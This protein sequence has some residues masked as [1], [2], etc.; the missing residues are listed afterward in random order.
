MQRVVRPRPQRLSPPLLHALRGS[1]SSSVFRRQALFQ[2]PRKGPCCTRC[3]FSKLSRSA[4]AGD[5]RASGRRRPEPFLTPP[6]IPSAPELQPT[7]PPLQAAPL[8]TAQPRTSCYPAARPQLRRWLSFRAH[9]D[10]LGSPHLVL[11]AQ[12]GVPELRRRLRGSVGQRALKQRPRV[13]QVALACQC[14]VRG[15]KQARTF[16]SWAEL[17]G[18]R[19]RTE[20]RDERAEEK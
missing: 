18:G 5:W 8:C 15:R 9:L 11:K 14:S 2:R 13:G 19:R 7:P 12:K 20:G 10:G 17:G 4:A 6:N 16:L 1:G 3:G